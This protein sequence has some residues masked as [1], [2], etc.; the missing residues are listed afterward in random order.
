MASVFANLP[1]ELVSQILIQR[2][3]KSSAACALHHFVPGWDICQ[4]K[5]R[6]LEAMLRLTRVDTYTV[7]LLDEDYTV[8]T[9]FDH[10]DDD[11][12]HFPAM[13]DVR[14][15]H[16]LGPFYHRELA[17]RWLSEC[18]IPV[19]HQ[20][21]QVG[22]V[23]G[24][25]LTAPDRMLRDDKTLSLLPYKD[26][27]FYRFFAEIGNPILKKDPDS[28]ER[29]GKDL[30]PLV[31]PVGPDEAS[32]PYYE[33]LRHLMINTPMDV[34]RMSVRDMVM[35]PDSRGLTPS[36]ERNLNNLDSALSSERSACLELDWRRL[37]GLETLFLD[38][39]GYSLGFSRG[40][41]RP[42]GLGFLG[43]SVLAKT[44]MLYR[45]G[46]KML[47]I[48]GLRS[49][50][51]YPGAQELDI[52]TEIDHTRETDPDTGMRYLASSTAKDGCN[53]FMMFRVAVR[54]GG[55]LIF[56]DKKTDGLVMSV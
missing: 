48:A 1:A 51:L 32:K 34:W 23:W 21:P 24:G 11:H 15:L 54:P 38:L 27:Q 42:L 37:K 17:K 5:N 55:K 29:N 18:L 30:I 6:G 52:E 45:G 26:D 46:L 22:P 9:R 2:Y 25:D 3:T 50:K 35:M 41:D 44:L 43:V 33:M 13:E 47:V 53:W 19:E 36:E 28:P 8:T 20:K 16:E 49:Y 7:P 12:I 39:R 10:G 40:D 14:D 31:E 4:R 56:V